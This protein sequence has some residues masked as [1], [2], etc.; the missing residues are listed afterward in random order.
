MKEDTAIRNDPLFS[1]DILLNWHRRQQELGGRRVHVEE[2]PSQ[3]ESEPARGS[4]REA[5]TYKSESRC[6]EDNSS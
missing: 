3:P 6:T 4:Q 1:S 5:C 2:L